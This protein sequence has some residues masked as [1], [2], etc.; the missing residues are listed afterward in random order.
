MQ[1]ANSGV[2]K[3]PPPMTPAERAAR[4]RSIMFTVDLSSLAYISEGYT[5][6]AI[7]RTVRSVCTTRRVTVA[8][9]RALTNV[10]FLD[11]LSLQ[12]YTFQD[13]K[14]A[15]MAFTKTITGMDDRRKKIEAAVAGEEEG[16]KDAKK[17]K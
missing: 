8:H 7:A 2:N 6:G 10:D 17:K 9:K 12:E 5:A 16:G 14:A 11:N 1:A 13:D 15:L 3:P 4:V